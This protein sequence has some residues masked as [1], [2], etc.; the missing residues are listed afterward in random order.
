MDDTLPFASKNSFSVILETLHEL[1]PFHYMMNQGNVGD[2]LIAAATVSLFEREELEF[3]PCGQ[4]LPPNTEQVTLVYG[5]GGGFV[6]YFGM[7]PHYIEVFSDPRI[8]TCVILPQSFRDCD[9]LVDVL[10]ERFTVFCRERAS[11]DYCI[12]RNGRARF[13]LADDM[14]L[15]GIPDEL[16]KRPVSLSFLEIGERAMGRCMKKDIK[17]SLV[18]L[19][20]GR[21]LALCLRRDPESTGKAKKLESLPLNTDLSRYSLRVIDD[22]NHAFAYA[23]WLLEALEQPDA[24][25]TDRLHLGIAAT[26]LGKEVF[27]MDNIYGKLFGIYELSLQKRFPRVQLLNELDEFPWLNEVLAVPDMQCVRRKKDSHARKIDKAERF[28]KWLYHRKEDNGVLRVK[29]CNLRV[30][31]KRVS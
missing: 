17:V 29:I 14:A 13:L 9:E 3:Y 10:D 27:M 1:G 22:V 24:I 28:S 2:A 12:S 30:C 6:P 21:K 16:R 4:E 8:R 7:L 11:Y 19:A 18:A 26:L 31:K 20:D 5:G 15:A 25:L 23:R